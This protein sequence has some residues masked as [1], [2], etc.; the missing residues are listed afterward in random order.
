MIQDLAQRTN[1]QEQDD[2]PALDT[3]GIR[4]RNG[5]TARY[6]AAV[7]DGLVGAV[8]YS[9][10]ALT[11]PLT[12]VILGMHRSGTSCVSRIVNISGAGLSVPVVRANASNRAGHWE[13]FESVAINEY[14]LHINGGTWQEPPSIRF[15]PFWMRLKMRRFIGS[16]HWGGTA[17]WKDPRTVLTFPLWKPLLRNYHILATVRHPLSVARSLQ[18]RDDFPLDQGLRLWREYNDRL[19]RISQTEEHVHWVDF[20]AGPE[21]FWDQLQTFAAATG[22]QLT[23]EALASYN[24]A[25]R[26]SDVA[27]GKLDDATEALYRKM[28]R[29]AGTAQ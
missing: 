7:R 4:L 24:P 17:V 19:V 14:I 18:S 15:C 10:Y 9:K 22:L 6:A 3:P 23:D 25:L 1:D 21:Q 20:D 5:R 26:T 2:A 16:L 11:K 13:P 27:H 28:R 12:I 8:G 29:L